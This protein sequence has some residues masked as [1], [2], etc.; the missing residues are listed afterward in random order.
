MDSHLRGGGDNIAVVEGVLEF[1]SSNKTTGV[2]NVGHEPCT[3]LG[4]DLLEVLIVPVP[5]IR[6]STT[7]DETGLEHLGGGFQFGVINETG[8][9]NNRIGEGLEVDGRG[10]H[11]LLSGLQNSCEYG[12]DFVSKH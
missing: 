7:D 12:I 10:S 2:G 11:L 8:I 4:S 3:L 1:L 9:G 6:G 5:G